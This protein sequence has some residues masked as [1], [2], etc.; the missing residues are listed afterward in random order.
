MVKVFIEL[1]RWLAHSYT[2]TNFNEDGVE[3]RLV[4]PS[5]RSAQEAKDRCCAEFGGAN[6]GNVIR[7]MGFRIRFF[8]KQH[9]EGEV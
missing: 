8:Y 3:V 4:F 9:S 6:V 1:Q 5:E 7:I 2:G